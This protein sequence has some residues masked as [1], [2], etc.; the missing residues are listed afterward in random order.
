MVE[1]KLSSFEE[2]AMMEVGNIGSGNASKKLSDMISEKVDLELTEIK[3]VNTSDL[4]KSYETD[5]IHQVVS[6]FLRVTGDAVGSIITLFDKEFATRMIDLIEKKAIGTTVAIT[7]QSEEQFKAMGIS[8][9]ESYVNSMVEF[10]SMDL[11]KTDPIVQVNK[12]NLVMKF[13]LRG[14]SPFLAEDVLVLRTRFKVDKY[15]LKGEFLILF[16]LKS[17]EGFKDSIKNILK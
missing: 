8:L 10:L 16:G 13:M 4:V 17:L 2:D 9:A 5:E 12:K 1:N 14:I 3:I 11:K 7:P 15:S 6:V